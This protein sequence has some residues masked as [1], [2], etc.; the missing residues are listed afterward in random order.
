MSDEQKNNGPDLAAIRARLAAVLA[1]KTVPADLRVVERGDL[2]AL[3]AQHDA[4]AATIAALTFERDAAIDN[5]DRLREVRDELSADRRRA[6]ARISELCDELT[7]LRARFAE[8]DATIAQLLQRAE[9]AELKVRELTDDL[10]SVQEAGIR[11]GM[12]RVLRMARTETTL[13]GLIAGLEGLLGEGAH[14]DAR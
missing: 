8:S 2:A 12:R 13:A 11:E 9:A 3:L 4:D 7:Q 10:A 14:D 6:T 1:Q 5:S